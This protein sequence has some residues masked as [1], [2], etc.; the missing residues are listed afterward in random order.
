MIYLTSTHQTPPAYVHQGDMLHPTAEAI[1]SNDTARLAELDLWPHVTTEGP[2]PLGYTDWSF[3]DG[4]YTREPSGTAEEIAAALEQQ[5]I[6]ELE[7]RRAGM[8]CSKAQ[9]K[10][11][12]LEAGLLDEVE[13]YIAT[14]P[15]A[16]QIE[17]ADRQEWRRDWPTLVAVASAR[18]LTDTKLDELFERAETFKAMS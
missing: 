6:A 15:K 12:L 16:V 17:Y 4:V 7:Q 11:A 14:Q 18:G 3:A 10:L 13:A 2:A 9:G 1:A 8:S 5:A